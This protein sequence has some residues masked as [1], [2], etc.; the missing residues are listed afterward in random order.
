MSKSQTV[1]KIKKTVCAKF[2]L[3]RLNSVVGKTL[4]RRLKNDFPD[5]YLHRKFLST[6]VHTKNQP[7]LQEILQFVCYAINKP[8]PKFVFLL[9]LRSFF[10]PTHSRILPLFIGFI[11]KNFNFDFSM[12]KINKKVKF[13]LNLFH[14]LHT[15]TDLQL[16][17]CLFPPLCRYLNAFS[18]W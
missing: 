2:S 15:P 3:S 17:T 10:I 6:F 9:L 4:R 12:T 1:Q 11:L 16:V 7:R 18:F 13:F 14:S 8:N 5:F